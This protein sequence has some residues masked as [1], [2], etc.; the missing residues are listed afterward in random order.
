MPIRPPALDD[1]NYESLVAELVARIPGHTPEWTHVLPGDPGRTLIELFAWMGD[2]LLYRA[3][4]IPE[5]QRLAFLRLLGT[6]MRPA[7]PA[8]GLVGLLLDDPID[9]AVALSPFTSIAKPMPFETLADIQVMPVSGECFIKRPLSESEMRDPETARLVAGLQRIYRLSGRPSPYETTPLFR[10]GLPV[11]QGVDVFAASADRCLWIAILAAKPDRVDAARKALGRQPSGARPL[12]NVGIVPALEVPALFE[13]IGPRAAI[14]HRWEST[15]VN[16]RGDAEYQELDVIEDTTG[17]LRRRGVVRLAM[18]A[19]DFLGAPLNDVR[20]RVTAGVGDQPPRLDSPELAARLVTW[21]RLR[22]DPKIPATTLNLSWVGIN[23]VEIDQRQ[24]MRLRLVGASSG[25]PDQELSLPAAPVDP[26]TL[27]IEVEEEGRGYVVWTPTD[28]LALAGRDDACYQVDAEAGTVRFG[29]GLRGRI[30]EAGRRVR[31]RQGRFGGGSAGTL[32]PGSITSL[33]APPAGRTIKV[34]QNLPTLGGADGETLAEAE[35][36]I[37]ALFRHKDRAITTDD[38]RKLAAE[39]PGVALGRVEVL[40]RFR[41]H[42]RKSDVPGVV[43]VMV[44]PQKQEFLPPNP[45]PDRPTLEAVHAH[46]DARRPLATE[47]YAIGCE[48]VKLGV[49]V[50]ISLFDLPAGAVAV[51]GQGGL[52]SGLVSAD[53]RPFSRDAVIVAVRDALRRF[54][55]PLAPGGYDGTGWPLGRSVRDRELEVVVARVPGVDAVAQVNLFLWT[56]DGFQRVTRRSADASLEIALR[57]WQLPELLSVVVVAEAEAPATLEAVNPFAR[58]ES[59]AV[60]VVPK[61]C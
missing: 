37:P 15:R 55:W 14:P 45:L 20:E 27:V 18:P 59:V 22:P 1:R 44:L 9:E 16:A 61:L 8:R 30:P 51:T 58:A 34:V 28:D 10:G 60:P 21:L 38:Y 41:P 47:L 35:A 43:S 54:L 4:L 40:A 56:E 25:A 6:G 53:G 23:A 7:Q 39:T 52:A 36:R 5:R 46:L 24:S 49:S 19:P 57:P 26:A 42:Q 32:P 33:A 48:Y 29:D 11:Q 3:N 13:E 31:V 50:G 17:G 2:A 12:L